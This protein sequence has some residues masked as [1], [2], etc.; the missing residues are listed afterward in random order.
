MHSAHVEKKA[1]VARVL[2]GTQRES[3]PGLGMH[4][5][6]GMSPGLLAAEVPL[7]ALALHLNLT[8]L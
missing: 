1:V 7:G 6:G 5:A 4:P 3:K 8:G 2:R